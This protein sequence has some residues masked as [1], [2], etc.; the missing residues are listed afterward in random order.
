MSRPFRIGLTGGIGMGKSMTAKMFADAGVAVW[1]A[2]AAVHRLYAKNGAAVPE[3]AALRPE[4]VEGG[5]VSRPALRAWI[6]ED[7]SALAQIEALVHPLVQQD[8]ADFAETTDAIIVLF[9]IPLL[10]ETGADQEMD[11][12]VT[13]S[14]SP[15]EQRR[16]VLERGSM[17]EQTLERILKAQMPDA[18]KQA[19]ADRV[20]ITDTV[21]N[22][23]A[24]VEAVLA[25]VR[26]TIDA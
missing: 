23:R 13:V 10:F 9:D 25:E 22:A 3:I 6:A 12:T 14:C 18:E 1:D 26:R 21:E 4:A 24:Q 16:R 20:I 11:L 17:D 19:Q 8:R 5:T 2:D 7:A 15:E